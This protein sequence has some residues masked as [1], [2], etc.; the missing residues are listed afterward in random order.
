MVSPKK[1]LGEYALVTFVI[2]LGAATSLW[3]AIAE[4]HAAELKVKEQFRIAASDRINV[5]SRAIHDNIAVNHSLV[6]FFL[7]SEVVSRSEFA[8]FASQI[9]KD[10]PY[11]EALEWLPRV[12]H[13]QRA[14]SEAEN[15]ADIPGFTFKD[16]RPDGSLIPAGHREIYY[17]VV[18]IEP[19]TESA[20]RIFGADFMNSPVRRAAIE[21]AL[22]TGEA[23]ATKQTIL[24]SSQ[25]SGILFFS[26]VTKQ[27][28]EQ[29]F[30]ASAV[31]LEIIV[32]KAI[33]PLN[34][35]GVNIIAYDVTDESSARTPLF[36]HS[37]RLRR[38]SDEE[39]LK[40]Y[41]TSALREEATLDVAQRKWRITIVPA[42]GFFTARNDKESYAI[43]ATGI[44]LTGML[45]Y[46]MISRIRENIRI[47]DLVELR[48]AEL[49]KL[50]RHDPLTG[51]PN[52]RYFLD[53]LQKALAR[54]KRSNTK[55]GILY[56][57]LNGFKP[58][59][60]TLGH[61]AGDALLKEFSLR[62]GKML[63]ESDVLAR[64]GGDEFAILADN[65]QGILGCKVLL[66]RLL[67]SYKEPHTIHKT[68]V[69]VGASIGVAIYPDHAQTLEEL[70]AAADAAMYRAKKDK[71]SD[72]A[73]A[74]KKVSR[75]AAK[76]RAK[77]R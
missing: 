44:L 1:I 27:K 14:K 19:E 57:D 13:R 30:I 47:S 71:K 5:I 32:S 12:E 55:V 6:S 23:A 43:F 49:E 8:S 40:N 17:P 41:H 72:Y 68:E 2:L 22:S 51:L 67:E 61:A 64:L 39:A 35:E 31:P 60:D 75:R 59:N 16:V 15:R 58:V 4:R 46:Y 29:G 77:K 33:E 53:M 45:A 18:Y 7:S 66:E 26:P 74:T 42:E 36:I 62:T 63:R 11:I 54:A 70:I 76:K 28:G 25:R 52:R 9:L 24:L 21:T 20:K 73:F 38:S 65:V 37:S 48:T 10:R 50:A 69:R 34:K 3:L 56:L